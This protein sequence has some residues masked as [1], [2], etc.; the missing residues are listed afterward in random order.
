MTLAGNKGTRLYA[1]NP[2]R[3]GRKP[4]LLQNR[5]IIRIEVHFGRTIFP[6]IIHILV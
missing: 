6:A 5:A 3:M 4:R 2:P 1:G